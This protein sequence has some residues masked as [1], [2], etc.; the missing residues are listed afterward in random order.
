MAT[1]LI[2]KRAGRFTCECGAV[3]E[4]TITRQ[5]MRDSDRI[6]CDV[7]SVEMDSWHSTFVP[8]YE[9][10]GEAQPAQPDLVVVRTL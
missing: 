9:L 5:P 6:F 8:S 3:Y 1:T 7:C 10:I 2:T 4:K